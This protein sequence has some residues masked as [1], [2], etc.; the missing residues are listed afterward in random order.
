MQKTRTNRV[1]EE[2]D[3]ADLYALKCLGWLGVTSILTGIVL[4]IIFVLFPTFL[5]DFLI[6][7]CLVIFPTFA[8]GFFSVLIYF[9]RVGTRSK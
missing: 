6:P 8:I 1:K 2:T 4:V 3:V 9:K 7:V 5:V